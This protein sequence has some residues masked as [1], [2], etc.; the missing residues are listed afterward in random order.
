MTGHPRD[1]GPAEGAGQMWP[2]VVAPSGRRCGRD[3][4]L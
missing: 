1:K 3:A 2:G 4:R